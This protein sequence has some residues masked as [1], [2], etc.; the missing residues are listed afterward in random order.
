MNFLENISPTALLVIAGI[1]LISTV[2]IRNVINRSSRNSS[3]MVDSIEKQNRMMAQLGMVLKSM[4]EMI[5]KND[6]RTD[7]RHK[8]QREY[9]DTK[10]TQ[11]EEL[12]EKSNTELKNSIVKEFKEAIKTG[13]GNND[14]DAPS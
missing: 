12:I 8:R 13:G 3:L 2:V 10:L 4:S 1:A 7:I 14:T 6:E 11:M 5:A 9:I